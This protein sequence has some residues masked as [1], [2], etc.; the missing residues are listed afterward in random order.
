MIRIHKHALEVTA[1]T[2]PSGAPFSLHRHRIAD[3][4]PSALQDP[5]YH[6]LRRIE[7][8]SPEARAQQGFTLIELLLTI[9]VA[10]ILMSIAIP[11]FQTFFSSAKGTSATN[12]LIV[13]AS[14][15]PSEAISRDKEV[16][17]CASSDMSSCSGDS[18]DWP[19]GWIV[20]V[21]GN[22]LRLWEQDLDAT[23][24]TKTDGASSLTY[25]SDGRLAKENKFTVN[26]DGCRTGR[27]HSVVIPLLGRPE[28]E[29]ETC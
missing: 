11:G 9:A 6:R 7:T 1:G 10:A 21:E 29:E 22:T 25:D 17:L 2:P 15:A 18:S 24:V 26:I 3:R 12:D 16:K 28:T 19:N 14:L 5:A 8:G 27:K 13:A 23:E 4:R 20:R